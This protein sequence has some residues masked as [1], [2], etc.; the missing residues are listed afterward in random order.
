MSRD[1]IF[2]PK[3]E[4]HEAREGGLVEGPCQAD[5]EGVTKVTQECID[6]TCREVPRGEVRSI[7]PGKEVG[8][9][10]CK[11][12]VKAEDCNG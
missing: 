2:V 8:D 4:L 3:E 7:T 1:G 6:E 10:G 9:L 12:V 5:R 11:V